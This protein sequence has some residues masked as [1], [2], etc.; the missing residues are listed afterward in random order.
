MNSLKLFFLFF[1]ATASFA[2]EIDMPVETAVYR[3]SDLPGFKLVQKNCVACHSAQY[4]TTQPP[5]STRNFWLATIH[6]M[7]KVY[8]APID[9]KEIPE[10][11]DY[12]VKLY[13]NEKP[14][15]KESVLR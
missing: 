15:T 1:I 14:V 5:N 9:E 6:K 11:V 13:G 4:V 2:M 8:A 7:E 12:L 10:M 3:P